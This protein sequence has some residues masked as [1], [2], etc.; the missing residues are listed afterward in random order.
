MKKLRAG[1]N[2]TDHQA[3][4]RSSV[5]AVWLTLSYNCAISSTVISWQK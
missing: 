3:R 4:K 2:R 5:R 1:M